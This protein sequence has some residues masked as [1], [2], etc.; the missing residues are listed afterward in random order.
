[1]QHHSLQVLNKVVMKAKEIGSC[2]RVLCLLLSLMSETS[3][4]R[5][6]LAVQWL[7]LCTCISGGTGLILG[8]KTKILYAT[9]MSTPLPKVYIDKHKQSIWALK[10][11]FFLATLCSMQDP[12]SMTRDWPPTPALEGRVLTAGPPGKA[13]Y[14]SCCFSCSSSY[15]ERGTLRASLVVQRLGI[16]FAMQGTQVQSLVQKDSTCC[17][18]T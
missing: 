13:S 16:C 8:L 4:P 2:V 12:S 15:V 7:G 9:C 1:M 17:G 6:S 18:A 10:K 3:S 14:G 11:I 5:N